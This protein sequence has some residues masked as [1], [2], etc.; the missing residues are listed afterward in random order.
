MDKIV[1]AIDEQDKKFLE[2][3]AEK[4]KI[5]LAGYCRMNLLSKKILEAQS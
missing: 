4:L 5:S 3:E 1:F 2:S